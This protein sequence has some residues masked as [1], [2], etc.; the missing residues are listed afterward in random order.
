[1]VLSKSTVLGVDYYN[2]C[3]NQNIF[4]SPILISNVSYFT[5]PIFRQSVIF[6]PIWAALWLQSVH[7]ESTLQVEMYLKS[8]GK[9]IEA[10]SAAFLSDF[11]FY[12]NCYSF[13]FLIPCNCTLQKCWEKERDYTIV[14][15]CFPQAP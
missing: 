14:N 1:M 5:V 7:L 13:E 2:F 6:I 3:S 8:I 10:V 15:R 4:R 12:C 9:V 11:L